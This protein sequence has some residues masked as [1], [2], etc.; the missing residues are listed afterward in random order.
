MKKL[1]LI[2][3]VI[4]VLLCALLVVPII[5]SNHSWPTQARDYLFDNARSDTGATNTVSAIYLGY[6]A[7]DTLGETLVLLVSVTGTMAI[8]VKLGK[9]HSDEE[10]T[11]FSLAPE[12]R[13]TNRLRT[14]LLETVASKLGPIVLLFGF[15]V[16]LYGHISPGGG[17]QGGV[18]VASAIV[19]LAL[20]TEVKSK[21]TN[22]LVLSRI[23]ALSFLVLILASISGVFFESGFFGN[24]IKSA[25]SLSANFI[26][27]LN[28]IIGLKVGTS[29]AVMCIAMMGGS[30]DH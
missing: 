8:L 9:E 15:Y 22:T 10:A 23:E 27:L 19:F 4:T 6:R 12:K 25:S 28:I 18:I 11:S 5:L 14:H 2:K 16:M 17:F 21:L 30:H 26:I 20:G 7:M 1:E 3:I 13:P 29:I 24:P